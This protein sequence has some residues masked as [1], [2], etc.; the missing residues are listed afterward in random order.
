MIKRK[1]LANLDFNEL[2]SIGLFLN[3]TR[4]LYIFNQIIGRED[5]IIKWVVLPN[6]STITDNLN[7]TKNYKKFVIQNQNSFFLW[8]KSQQN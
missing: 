7:S 6:S 3:G 4:G 2:K 8:Q 5:V 1:V